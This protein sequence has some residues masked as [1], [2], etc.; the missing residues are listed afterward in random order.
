MAS[1]FNV[2][3]IQVTAEANKLVEFKIR[4]EEMLEIY[5][6]RLRW[7]NSDS[8]RLFGVITEQN[9]CLVLDCKQSDA[10]KLSQFRNSLLNL[11]CEQLSRLRSFN[12]IRCGADSC[13]DLFRPAACAV[14][15][16][17][18]D[19]AIEWLNQACDCH[20][21]PSHQCGLDTSTCEAVMTAFQDPNVSFLL[22]YYLISCSTLSWPFQID[23]VYLISEGVSSNGL[24][25]ILYDKIVKESF[26]KQIKFN[27][28]SYNC[29]EPT[30]IEYL[31][32]L[33]SSSFGPGQ[34]HA[35]CLLRE[36][37]DFAAGPISVCPTVTNVVVNR[38]GFGGAPPGAGVKPDQM[39]LFEEIQASKEALDNINTILKAM[40]DL[41]VAQTQ[42]SPDV[43]NSVKPRRK[44]ESLNSNV[45]NLYVSSKEWLVEN[46]L[47]TKRLDLCSVL[48]S[49]SF[50]HCDA[51]IDVKDEPTTGKVT[52]IKGAKYIVG[53]AV[54]NLN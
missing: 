51:V 23:A 3:S 15:V 44:I 4:L 12:M 13:C 2:Q 20:F 46:G 10:N 19:E 39:V 47:A 45:D 9:V 1:L 38:R 53:D 7:L 27:I 21:G 18:I 31:K 28:A 14:S 49:V 33:A 5:E 32:R 37:D 54:N 36:L 43:N 48:E 6:T 11:V 35:Y 8:R 42:I 22:L 29:D 50:M 26:D 30:T 34:F 25:E 16:K 40:S 41:K 24:R 52:F 17:S